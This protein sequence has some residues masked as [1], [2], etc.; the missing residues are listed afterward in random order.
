MSDSDSGVP[1]IKRCRIAA[2][3]EKSWEKI[4]EVGKW[5]A[6]SPKGREFGRCRCCNE[7]FSLD[8]GLASLAQHCMQWS[9][10]FCLTKVPYQH[11]QNLVKMFAPAQ[12]KIDDMFAK[13]VHNP[14]AAKD[15][16]N[17]IW[18]APN[19]EE[20]PQERLVNLSQ[21]FNMRDKK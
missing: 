19:E 8:S 1:P 6:R 12:T 7:D 10:F 9:H 18:H 16:F 4:P 2:G 21:I 15:L 11:R 20:V 17:F 14:Q 5:L 3:Y 13:S